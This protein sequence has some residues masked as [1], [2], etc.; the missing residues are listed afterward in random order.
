MLPISTLSYRAMLTAAGSRQ[1][2]NIP[3]RILVGTLLFLLPACT[4]DG[5]NFCVLGY[6]TQPNYDTSIHTVH[7][8][9]FKNDTLRRGLEF[10][11]TRAVVREIEAKTPY[12]VVSDCNHADTEL[13]GTIVTL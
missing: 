2:N 3:F 9:I 1:H 4:S 11:L 13:T 12:K 6:T 5:K 8:P 10:E 7:V